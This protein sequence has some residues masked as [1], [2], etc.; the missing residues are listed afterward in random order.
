M[1]LKLLLIIGLA[2]AFLLLMIMKGGKKL[3]FWLLVGSTFIREINVPYLGPSN[4]AAIG[5]IAL[6]IFTIFYLKNNLTSRRILLIHLLPLIVSFIFATISDVSIS[7]A[8][9]WLS[10]FLVVSL[11]AVN[12]NNFVVSRED[13]KKLARV[14]IF[15]GFVFSFTAVIAYLGFADGV[16]IYNGLRGGSENLGPIAQSRIYGISYNNLISAI[17][18]LMIVL[19]PSARWAKKWDWGYIF[20]ASFSVVISF[21]R[22][23]I[24]AL[25]LSIVYYLWVE[26]K[27]KP[28]TWLLLI[29]GIWWISS[30][31]FLDS[32][33]NRFETSLEFFRI[34]SSSDNSSQIRI[35]RFIYAWDNFRKYPLFGAGAGSL[36]YIHNG[37]IE[38]L[39]NMGI[40]GTLLFYSIFK[41]V[42]IRYLRNPW[43]AALIIYFLTLIMFEASINRM[44]IMY[45]W[46]IYFG[47]F[48]VHE[49]LRVNLFNY[50]RNMKITPEV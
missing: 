7:R 49:R 24:M 25:A 44:D 39:A 38:I 4:P 31:S 35:N 30:L 46:G 14:S 12:I 40:M 27:N 3:F 9:E 22:L 21:K 15:V 43:A 10:P 34:G 36:V 50:N 45:F 2:F 33:L 32:V 23:A 11:I 18:A 13:E 19:L 26:G 28:A 48:M 6:S 16:I 42:R 1:D 20:I 47:G 41:V 17:S 29:V 5:F 8:L 37:I